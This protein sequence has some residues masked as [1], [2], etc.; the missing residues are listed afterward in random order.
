VYFEQ[1]TP[2]IEYYR[3]QGVLAEIDGEKP[4]AEV[5]AALLAAV[6]KT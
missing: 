3:R 1:T 6:K 5:T 2:L 4:I